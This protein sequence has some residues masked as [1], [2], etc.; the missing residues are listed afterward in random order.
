MLMDMLMKKIVILLAA[1]LIP[2]S[3]MGQDD[4]FFRAGIDA[5]V[6]CFLGYSSIMPPSVGIGARARL[7]KPSQWVNLV[8][9]VRYIY[10]RRLSGFQ[11]PIVVNVNLLRGKLCSGYLGAGYEFDFIGTYLGCMK[12]Q[13]G[14]AARHLD[15]RI[16][17]KPYQGDLGAGFT[18]YF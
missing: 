15:F 4:K 16:F 7:G 11:V 3:M 6:D 8:G 1:I 13:V 5:S 18:Y 17:Y 10:G 12:F 14:V 2:L 9:G